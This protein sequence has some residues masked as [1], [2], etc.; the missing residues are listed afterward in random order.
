MIKRCGDYC[1]TAGLRSKPRTDLVLPGFRQRVN[2]N[3]PHLNSRHCFFKS[4]EGSVLVEFAM[5][6]SILLAMVFGIM[7][8]S[9]AL[10][11][12]RFM[13]Y[14]ATEATR[15]AVVR[16]TTFAGSTCVSPTTFDCDATSA[17]LTSY[18]Q[19]LAP[20][21]MTPSAINVTTT[22]PGTTPTGVTCANGAGNNSPSC[23]VKVVVT[24]VFSFV[25]PFLPMSTLTFSA[26]STKTILE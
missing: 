20:P 5:S 22:W 1:R 19:G 26:T 16:G 25:M 4:E 13:A 6:L 10:Y 3:K 8:F 9:R 2:A 18:V 24:Y 14:A 23:V 17:N 7:E 11:A 15:Y 12:Y 21:G